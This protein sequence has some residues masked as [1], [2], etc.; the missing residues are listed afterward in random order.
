VQPGGAIHVRIATQNEVVGQQ[1]LQHGAILFLDGS[2]QSLLESD[3]VR[4]IRRRDGRLREE[5]TGKQ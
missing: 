4:I 2:I 3:D 1:T 5:G